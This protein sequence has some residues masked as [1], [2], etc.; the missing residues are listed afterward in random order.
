MIAEGRSML[1]PRSFLCLALLGS[2]AAFVACGSDKHSGG[3]DPNF[4]NAGSGPTLETGTGGSLSVDVSPA[5]GAGGAGGDD[6]ER[7][8]SLTAVTLGAP[9][10]FDL[11]IVADHSQ[12]LAW[13]RDELS[14]GL[15]GLLEDARGRDVRIFLLTPTQYG[16]SSAEAEMPLSGM[17]VVDWKDPATGQA[18]TNA[19]TT[20]V[21]SCTDPSGA[22]MAC[23][24]SKAT[25]PY[26]AEGTWR[27]DMP[28]P[29]ATLRADMSEAEFAAQQM[30]VSDA[31]L[32]IGGTG[33]P[34]EQPL[35]TLARY[36]SQP[37]EKLPKNAVFLLISDEDD[38]S[39]PNK[40]L[41]GY[42]AE[43]T[44][45]RSEASTTPCSSNCDTYRYYADGDSSSKTMTF[46]CAA[47]DD[48]GKEIP[49]TE[50]ESTAY[51]G[52]PSCAEVQ[53]GACTD[54][55]EKTV[56]NFCAGGSRV[57]S[58]VRGCSPNAVTCSVDLPDASVNACTQAFSKNGIQYANLA[59]Y[60]KA[61]G[62]GSSFSNCRGGGL[63]IEYVDTVSG[64]YSP[65]PL[66]AGSTAADIGSYFK[67]RADAA[68][69][70][71]SYLVEAIVFD[72]AFSCA[73]G[74]GQSYATTLAGVVGDRKRLFPLC[75]PYAPALDGVLSFAQTLVQTSFPL[76]LKPD[77]QVTFVHVTDQ[78]GAERALGPSEFTYDSTTQILKVQPSSLN[79]TDRTLRVEI[80]SD[81]RPIVK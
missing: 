7:D 21:K 59:A 16:A 15:K 75:Q 46:T 5:G 19:M 34:Y 28:A 22:P 52:T 72:P 57:V 1:M 18:Y 29:I 39:V 60:C 73:L 38:S 50:L 71:S 48:T 68:F 47:F 8:V 17:S 33:S 66:T 64:G 11:I 49:G 12:S 79:A 54:D 3:G 63:D 10:P 14:A 27:F 36:V 25:T 37:P 13:S 45:S 76:A 40:C 62:W 56:S 77:E 42:H 24:D 32:A 67:T 69:G 43:L 61:I 9:A 20:F 44:Q 74:A 35:C 78:F 23:P 6:C 80:T 4:G 51:Q 55:E 53:A 65:Q 58:C 30:A 81:C 41:A 26:K 2:V 31:I 70:T